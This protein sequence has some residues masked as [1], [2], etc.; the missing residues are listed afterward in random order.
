MTCVGILRLCSILDVTVVDDR[1]KE[2]T[3]NGV[4]ASCEICIQTGA[5]FTINRAISEARPA[6]WDRYWGST[7]N[8]GRCSIGASMMK[9]VAVARSKATIAGKAAAERRPTGAMLTW[10]WLLGPAAKPVSP[11]LAFWDGFSLLLPAT[12][13]VDVDVVTPL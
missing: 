2:N 13:F 7:V 6:R 3:L 11:R 5:S 1:N 8:R 10:R 9:N 4:M 12:C